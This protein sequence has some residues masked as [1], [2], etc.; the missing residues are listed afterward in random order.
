MYCIIFDYCMHY[1]QV[2]NVLVF[3]RVM[4][5]MSFSPIGV[6]FNLMHL[7][8][9]VIQCSVVTIVSILHVLFKSGCQYCRGF[10][11]VGVQVV[12]VVE[13]I[14]PNQLGKSRYPLY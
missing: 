9:G 3:L 2:E 7:F 6:L 8:N 4:A 13:T 14:P 11:A 5:C 12:L 10:M 1:I